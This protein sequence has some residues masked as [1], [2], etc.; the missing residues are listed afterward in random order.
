MIGA[1]LIRQGIDLRKSNAI[2]NDKLGPALVKFE[3][4]VERYYSQNVYAQCQRGLERKERAKEAEIGIFAIGTD[5]KKVEEIDAEVIP[6]CE[7]LKRL[8]IRR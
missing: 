1:E 5:W 6:S 3:V 8:G 7:E 2:P 4:N